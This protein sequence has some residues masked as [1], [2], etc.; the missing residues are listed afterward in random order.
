MDE[1]CARDQPI[2]PVLGV[3]H[4]NAGLDPIDGLPGN[5]AFRLPVDT[6]LRQPGGARHAGLGDSL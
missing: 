1:P 6:V 4:D 3:G 5:P 2:A